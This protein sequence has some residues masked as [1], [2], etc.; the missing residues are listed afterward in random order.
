MQRETPSESDADRCR[1]EGLRIR[2]ADPRRA[3][4]SSDRDE[5]GCGRKAIVEAIN[6]VAVMGHEEIKDLVQEVLNFDD[7]SSGSDG[8]LRVMSTGRES[9]RIASTSGDQRPAATRR[10]LGISHEHEQGQIRVRS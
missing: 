5:R 1:V 4:V 3:T 2:T 7:A 8:R 10:G 6:L 9:G